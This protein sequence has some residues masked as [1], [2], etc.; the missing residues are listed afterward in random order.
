MWVFFLSLINLEPHR[1]LLYTYKS[2][3]L[4]FIFLDGADRAG[5]EGVLEVGR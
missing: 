3:E 2:F 4:Y 1:L 5:W